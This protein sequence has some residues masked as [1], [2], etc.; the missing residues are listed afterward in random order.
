MYD[1]FAAFLA[2]TVRDRKLTPKR[3]AEMTGIPER[4]LDQFLAGDTSNLPSAPFIHGYVVKL[5]AALDFDGEAWWKQ[6]KHTQPMLSS[7]TADRMPRNRFSKNRIPSWVLWGVPLALILITFFGFRFAS[8]LGLPDVAIVI[9]DRDGFVATSSPTHLAGTATP[10]SRVVI[11]GEA[12]PL[13]TDGTWEKEVTLQPGAQNDF[14][15]E[16]TKFLGRSRS[17]SRRIFFE[18]P[19]TTSTTSTVPVDTTSSST[20]TSDTATGTVPTTTY[21][22]F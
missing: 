22:E 19:A 8:I 20:P 13:S 9:P 11:N 7:G 1:E 16:V 4:A 3:L 12:I 18:P 2:A 6:L 15:V 10:G 14:T 21:V 17:A 5:G